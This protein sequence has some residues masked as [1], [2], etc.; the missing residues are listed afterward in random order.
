MIK[1][2]TN[3]N[4]MASFISANPGCRR[5]DIKH[6][7]FEARYGKKAL[8]R[9]ELNHGNQYFSSY[10]Q[11]SNGY[12][13]DLWFNAFITPSKSHYQLTA[14]GRAKV[15][16]PGQLI[17]PFIEGAFVEW[18]TTSPN[19]WGWGPSNYFPYLDYENAYSVHRGLS[20]GEK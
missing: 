13:N 10:N 2:I 8:R 9:Y 4:L 1:R 20:R 17:R 7:L 19:H 3:V 5:V 11:K 6:H 14:R 15:I 12:L 16:E 18:Q